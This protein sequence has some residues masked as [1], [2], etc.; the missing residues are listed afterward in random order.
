MPESQPEPVPSFRRE[1]SRFVQYW[2][3]TE[4]PQALCVF[5]ILLG[6]YFL[7]G[8][9]SIL[10]RV[11]LYYS[12]EGMA[13]PYMDAPEGA[14]NNLRDVLANLVQPAPVWVAWLLYGLMLTLIVLII[15]GWWTRSALLL[16]SVMY[17]YYWLLQLHSLQSSFDRLLFVITVMLAMGECD[18][19]YSL[20]AWIRKMR[21]ERSVELIPIWPARLIT[22]QIAFMYVG[23]GIYKIMTPAWAGGDM[24][25]YSFQGDWASPVA[26]QILQL[27]LSKGVYDFVILMT[28]L[29]ELWAPFLLFHQTWQKLFFV[30]GFFFHLSISLTLNI[31]PFMIMPLTYI[32]F[33]EPSAFKQFCDQV[34][35]K[36]QRP[37]NRQ[38]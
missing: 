27:P 29:L 36:W 14:S 26:F 3:G 35:A 25:I 24:L 5:R 16:F 19:V 11:E 1:F 6:F 12:V 32:L 33:V 34:A 38:A 28:I 10:P 7:I 18:A 37:A 23:T 31:W 20:R 21:G 9:L 2:Y 8:W 30:L 13:F 4:P 15:V 17:S 22:M